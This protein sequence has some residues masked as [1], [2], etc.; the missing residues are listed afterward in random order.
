VHCKKFKISILKGK[1]KSSHCN[2]NTLRSHI[3]N[4]PHSGI[5]VYSPTYMKTCLIICNL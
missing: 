4:H 5:G 3:M 2:V 1:T